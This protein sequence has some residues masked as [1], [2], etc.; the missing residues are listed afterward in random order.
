MLRRSQ[1]FVPANDERKIRKS[2]TLEADSIIF[3]LEDS[4][5]SSEKSKGRKLLTGLFQELDFGR[6]EICLRINQLGSDLSRE[7]VEFA[8]KEEKID[9]LIISKA[10]SL[11]ISLYKTTQKAMIPLVETAKGVLRI[12]HLVRTK[13]VEAISYGPADL[14]NSV[15]GRVE[16][17]SQNIFLK[18]QMVVAAA[19]YGVDAIDGVYFDLNNVDGFRREAQQSRDLGFVGKQVVHPSQIII[20]NEVYAPS[21]EDIDQ[22]K[23]L[24]DA[25]ERSLDGKVGAIRYRENLVDA[26]H[27][28][29]AKA[30]LAKAVE[31]TTRRRVL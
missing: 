17:F 21:K 5:P 18:T 13:G 8:R 3:D 22:A 1:L 26:V 27:Y 29:R 6:R 25:Y 23:E 12:E 4:V 16:S 15:G 7:D 2:V 10:E 31:V 9:T 28:R 24:I 19:S 20:A 14:A 11:P 30:I